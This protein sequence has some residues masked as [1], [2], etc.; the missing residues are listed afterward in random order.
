MR[1]FRCLFYLDTFYPTTDANSSEIEF[2]F[3]DITATRSA[4]FSWK[5]GKATKKDDTLTIPSVRP[6]DKLNKELPRDFLSS[7]KIEIID[8]EGSRFPLYLNYQDQH[9]QLL[10]LQYTPGQ[11]AR[12]FAS[13]SGRNTIDE[14]IRESNAKTKQLNRDIEAVNSEI[15]KLSETI[16]QLSAQIPHV[17]Y[18]ITSIP[19]KFSAF[20]VANHSNSQLGHILSSVENLETEL[21]HVTHALEESQAHIIESNYTNYTKIRTIYEEFNAISLQDVPEV[22]DL[23]PKYSEI[24]NRYRI[25]KHLSDIIAS[26]SANLEEESLIVAQL[27]RL[28][29]TIN[30]KCKQLEAVINTCDACPYSGVRL[31]DDCKRA[32]GGGN[33]ENG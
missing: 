26:Y 11:L 9:D 19:I 8:V 27:S 22:I 1:A 25:I 33:A 4:N 29:T 30:E 3:D 31:H 5:E 20:V 15:S 32:L 12:I 18:D 10:P 6:W 13:L 24:A 21:E 7:T 23:E 28:D 14:A 17:E 16:S 2:V